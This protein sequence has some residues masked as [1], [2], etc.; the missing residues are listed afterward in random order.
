[1]TSATTGRK[2]AASCLNRLQRPFDAASARCRQTEDYRPR[3]RISHRGRGSTPRSA[4]GGC[5]PGRAVVA[6]DR[7]ARPAR[8]ASSWQSRS[9]RRPNRRQHPL[10]LCRSADRRGGGARVAVEGR[11]IRSHRLVRSRA[12]RVVLPDG[13]TAPLM[14][15]QARSGS[16]SDPPTRPG[17]WSGPFVHLHWSNHTGC[18]LTPQCKGDA[19]KQPRS[20]GAT[21]ERFRRSTPVWWAWLDLNQRPHPYQQSRAHRYATLRFCRLPWPGSSRTRPTL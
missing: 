9:V 12:P 8:A 18:V 2:S 17:S 6:Q 11:T 16:G 19:R 20:K 13:P 3:R 7:V 1:M 21:D 10:R 5:A 4:H 15:F 14:T